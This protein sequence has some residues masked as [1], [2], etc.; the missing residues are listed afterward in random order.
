MI[1][2][3]DENGNTFRVSVDDPRYIISDL[4]P[5]TKGM[6][7]KIEDTTNYK[8]SKSKAILRI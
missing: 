4:V 6:S 7:W 2:V 8:K 1:G 3:K 5:I